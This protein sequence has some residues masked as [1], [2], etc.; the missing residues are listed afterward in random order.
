MSDDTK[1]ER[2]LLKRL[3]G[4]L[5]ERGRADAPDRRTSKRVTLPIPVRLKIGGGEATTERLRD[6]SQHGLSIEAV[7]SGEPGERVVVHFEGYPD[8]CDAFN[9]AGE[10]A[11]VSQET[12]HGLVIQIDRQNTPPDAL[13]QYRALVLHYIR[14]KPLLEELGK[15]YFEGRCVSCD[16]I[17]RVGAT[18]PTCPRCGAGAV[19]IDAPR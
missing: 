13:Q 14:H 10:I 17:G 5:G 11:R 9:L 6:F 15:G 1:R 18:K 12:P 8:V 16:W 19:P 3:K 2:G 7:S 4:V